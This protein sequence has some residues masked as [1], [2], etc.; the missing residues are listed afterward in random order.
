MDDEASSAKQLMGARSRPGRRRGADA[1]AIAAAKAGHLQVLKSLDLEELVAAEDHNGCA[2]LHWAAGN[3]NLEVCR[4]L[5]ERLGLSCVDRRTWNQ[6]TPLHYAARN[7][8]RD[9]CRWLIKDMGSDADALA[10]DEVT[11]F[12]L[13]V[14]QNHLP[15][16]QFF[17]DEA[18]INPLQRNRFG[19]SVTHWLALA[20]ASRA[21]TEGARQ[22][23]A[24]LPLAEWLL[25]L[26]CDFAAVQEHGHTALH[27]AAWSGHGALCQWL[28]D[29]CG[30]RDGVQD[31]AG[32]FA[33]DLAD[34]VGHF[35]ISAWLR[36]ECSEA[37][38]ASCRVL[39]VASDA[40]QAT[41]RAAYLQ[42]IRATHPDGQAHAQHRQL[43]DDEA[44][45]GGARRS[46][47]LEEFVALHAAWRHLTVE[48]GR[49]AQ[50][51]PRHEARL[52]L[53]AAPFAEESRVEH[54]EDVEVNATDRSE[55]DEAALFK[56]RLLTVIRE[57]GSK[58][59]PVSILRR[60]YAQVWGGAALP[61]PATF[62][63]RRGCG[64]LELVRH[65]AGDVV[66]V[67]VAGAAQEPLLHALVATA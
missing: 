21:T 33:A 15:T 26:G 1:P 62:G 61:N 57:F 49:G 46:H 28:R 11:P 37:R 27:K 8:Q 7:G 25:D 42:Q 9:V 16:C 56:A 44:V 20:P 64:V 52:M 10:R 13:A 18:G 41:I 6:R 59:F 38:A 63:L 53:A 43:K 45:D 2:C 54:S 58:G 19:C 51:N 40:D 3:G 31:E 24:L 32:N 60:K 67:E 12:Q 39:G 29:R 17:V 5:V 14:W 23:A 47:G 66:R 22:G 35:E 65:A 36:H 48:G 30:L 4:V 34:M 50:R 55:A